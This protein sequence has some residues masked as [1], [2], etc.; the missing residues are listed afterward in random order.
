MPRLALSLPAELGSLQEDVS[1]GT[2]NRRSL[3]ECRSADRSGPL[4]RT[5]ETPQIESW[6]ACWSDGEAS[7]KT[8]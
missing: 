8:R 5:D 1:R 3:S 2:S 4:D 6:L 7:E